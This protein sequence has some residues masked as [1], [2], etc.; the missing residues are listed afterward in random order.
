MGI[1]G[2]AKDGLQNLDNT[3]EG[4]KE[5]NS[6]RELS[7][8]AE[9]ELT[10]E[11][12]TIGEA[13]VDCIDPELKCILVILPSRHSPTGIL[14]QMDDIVFEWILL[15]HKPNKKLKTY[16]E[17]VSDLIQKDTNFFILCT[18][19]YDCF[20][21]D[22]NDFFPRTDLRTTVSLR[23]RLC[24]SGFLDPVLVTE[25]SYK[26]VDTDNEEQF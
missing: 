15:P 10:L 25:N 20:I 23:H 9:K 4:D 24:N 6:P 21:R 16:T 26:T 1:M 11:E 2:R 13:H 14:M 7:A 18:V 22:L 5:L 8:E 12:K 3:L 17:K 19:L